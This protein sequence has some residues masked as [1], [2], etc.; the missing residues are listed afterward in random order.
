MGIFTNQKK[1]NNQYDK[2]TQEPVGRLVIKLGIPTTISMLVTNIYN[3]ADTM[4][5]GRLGT[6]AS[7]A[8]GIVFGF[9]AIIQ[10]F[11]FMYGQGAGSIISRQLGHKDKENASRI[12]S[13]SFFLALVTGAIIGIIGFIFMEPLMYLLGSTDTILPY[14][15]EYIKYILIAAPFMAS[16]FVMNNILR[17]E[18]KAI[19]A[20]AGLLTGAILNMAGDP[21][22]MF[23]LGMGID[24]AG[25]STALSQ[26][27]SFAILLFMFVSGRTESKIS[28]RKFTRRFR[29]IFD[30][31][32]TGFPSL[33]RQGLTSI[34][35]MLLNREARVYGDA[36]VS[37]M[38]IVSRISMFI[39]SVGLGIGQGFQPVCGFNYGAGKY[40]RVKKA[41]WFTLMAS[42]ILMGA[43]AVAGL[44][45]SSQAI[46]IFRDDA[47]VI[48]FGTP[49]LRYQCV[50][51]FLQPLT[52]LSNMTLQSTGQKIGATIV[53]MLR[54]GVYFIPTL[55]VMTR[56]MG[57]LG[58]QLAQPVAD[59]LA[60]VTVIPFM[61]IFF[62]KLPE[63]KVLE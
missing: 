45:G 53:S 17:F 38:S 8:V 49:A 2:M 55:L 54:S 6:S 3:M 31:V 7:G 57:F 21:F 27:V 60:F 34:S 23:V 16:S 30:I 14:A 56:S 58:I 43:F 37:A 36:A 32:A 48:A 50:A 41:F 44:L 5:V 1:Y 9:M 19:L 62:K 22:F 11:G 46:G 39:F 40:T 25:L 10:A 51:L 47:E 59:V 4:F 52:V 24:G 18:G 33:V 61:I 35:T 29:D 42:E 15:K 26:V 13:T 12:A 20:M 63:D 28:I